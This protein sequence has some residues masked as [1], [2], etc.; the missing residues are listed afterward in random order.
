MLPCDMEFSD[1]VS[2]ISSRKERGFVPIS[3]FR[4]ECFGAFMEPRHDAPKVRIIRSHL[5][6]YYLFFVSALLTIGV[7][8]LRK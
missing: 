7:I 1:E 3:S 8:L 2:F 6:L 5:V 4:A